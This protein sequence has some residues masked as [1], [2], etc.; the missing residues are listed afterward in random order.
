MEQQ[1]VELET[2][3]AEPAVAVM[4]SAWKVCRYSRRLQRLDTGVLVLGLFHAVRG[5]M[6]TDHT[7]ARATPNGDLLLASR[8][9]AALQVKIMRGQIG[10]SARDRLRVL[11]PDLPVPWR[12]PL[13]ARLAGRSVAE[14]LRKLDVA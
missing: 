12:R 9:L 10:P 4:R 3:E 8:L 1:R 13:L 5:K 7:L 2:P 11:L 14:P 6:A